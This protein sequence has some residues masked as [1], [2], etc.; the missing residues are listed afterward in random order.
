MSF[1]NFFGIYTELS[2]LL[3]DNFLQFHRA[4]YGKEKPKK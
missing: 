2:C 3:E 4:I 1:K